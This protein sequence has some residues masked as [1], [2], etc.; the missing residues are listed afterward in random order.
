VPRNFPGRSGNAD[1]R[2]YLCSPETAAAAALTG[3]ITDPRELGMDYPRPEMPKVGVDLRDLLIAPPPPAEAKTI[4]IVYGPNIAALPPID[5]PADAIAAPVLLKMADNISTDTIN[6]AGAEVMPYRANVQRIAEFSFRRLDE[7][8]VARAKE[9]RDTT[10]HALV[11]GLNYGQGSSREHAALA[12]QW[13]GLKLVLVKSFARIHEQ[14]LVNA[15][16]LA[17]TFDNESDYDAIGAGDTLAVSGVRD[18]VAKGRSIA[19]TVPEK[20]LEI[21]ATH[22]MSGRQVEIFLVGGLVNWFKA[23]LRDPG[24]AG[25]DAA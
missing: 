18:A 3:R 25:A 20:G 12:P 24:G 22:N 14:N 17:L 2:V 11:G 23:R 4:E 5:P 16:V 15:G 13:L 8:Y 21:A 10:G 19:V 6:P 1:D 7:T 9:T